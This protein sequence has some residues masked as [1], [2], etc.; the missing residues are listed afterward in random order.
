MN[1][2]KETKPSEIDMMFERA[3]RKW[4]RLMHVPVAAVDSK[5]NTARDHSRAVH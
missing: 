5:N 3:S 1:R 2:M 4:I